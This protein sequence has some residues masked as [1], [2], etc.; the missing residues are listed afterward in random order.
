MVPT[1]YVSF[2]SRV[3]GTFKLYVKVNDEHIRG[4]PFTTRVKPFHVKPVLCFGEGGSGDGMF[5]KPLGVAVT[6]KDEILVADCFNH[7]VQVFDSNG[8][9]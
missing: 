2:Y 1:N 5:K 7:R 9:S 6:D 4:S 8:T 3:Q